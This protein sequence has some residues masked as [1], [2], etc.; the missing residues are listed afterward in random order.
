ME[1]PDPR[2][3]L[4][5]QFSIRHPNV[6]HGLQVQPEPGLH[7]EEQIVRQL[8]DNSWLHLFR[9]DPDTSAVE[10]RRDGAW[11]ALAADA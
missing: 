5:A 1:N 6:V 10:Q 9:I 4:G 7:A 3:K 11:Q 2:R 8:V